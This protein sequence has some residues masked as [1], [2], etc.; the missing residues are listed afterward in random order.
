MTTLQKSFLSLLASAYLLTATTGCLDD[1]TNFP[2]ISGL[3]TSGLTPTKDDSDG[4]GLTDTQEKEL[5]TDPNNPD[6]D[7]DGLNDGAE[8]NTTK[9]DPLNPDTDGDGLSDGD[10]VLKH[11]TDPNKKD[12]D[13][14]GLEDGK[15]IEIGTDPLKPDTD[16]DG[17]NDGL[18]VQVGTKPQSEFAD[19]DGDGVTDGIEV[20]GTKAENIA[21]NGKV[22]SAGK[23]QIPLKS[24]KGLKVLD[25]AEPISIDSFR[26]DYDNTAA[27]IHY[28]PLTE[29][30]KDANIIDAL[31]PMNDSDYDQRPNLTETQKGTDPLDQN[32]KY[33]W[34]YETPKGVEMEKAG[35]V[36]IPA[37]DGNGGFWMSQYEARPVNPLDTTDLDFSSIVKNY[38]TML[39]GETISGFDS[40]DLSGTGL[41]T[42]NFNNT[43][44]SVR[45]I[46][47]FEAAYM[48]DKSQIANGEH[49]GLPSLK[50]YAHTMKLLSNN[51]V[52]NS[53]LYYD[54]QVEETYERNIYEL[55]SGVKE[56]T[57]TI[58]GLPYGLDNYEGIRIEKNFENRA[59]AGSTINNSVGLVSNTALAILGTGFIDLRYSISYADNGDFAIGFRAA[60]DYIK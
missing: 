49:I 34:I 50:Q 43:N 45:G 27:N 23:S 54:P 21:E 51:S 52:A 13:G 7:G 56:F 40:A 46:Y 20:L 6:T 22:I 47:G 19:T 37:I 57:N 16:G 53:V 60:S 59:Y 2:G 58:V 24:E 10:E 41:S 33:P 48:L 4:D 31:D 9:T 3:G 32:S 5:G 36:Y 28:N 25:I 1:R 38:F 15:E 44:D 35:F 11:K 8:V 12:T 55:Q 26:I 42:V 18:E 14:D 39:T 17:L 29:Y 30:E